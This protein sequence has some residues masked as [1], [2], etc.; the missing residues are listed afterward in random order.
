M[1]MRVRLAAGGALA[2]LLAVAAFSLRPSLPDAGADGR[3]V[4]S[5]DGWALVKP[6]AAVDPAAVPPDGRTPLTP[7]QVRQRLFREGSFAGTEPTGDWCVAQNRLTACSAL[8]ARFEYYLL[9]LGEVT[10]ADLRT[11]VFD[12]ATR[13]HGE[14]LARQIM[15]VWDKYWQLRSHAWRH[16]HDQ[17]DRSTWMPVFEE[18]R[19]VRRQ[20]LGADWAQAF[21]ADEEARFQAHYAQLESGLPPPPDPGEPVPQMA[22]GKDPA[23]VHAERVARYGEAAATRL[24]RADDEW[25]DWQ[26][27]LGA[28][29][30][31]WQRLQASPQLSDT[32]RRQEM[33]A[34]VGAHFKPDEHLRVQA[35][36]QL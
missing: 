28:A 1:N 5:T 30:Q 23:A 2:A 31:E 29:R 18:Q 4:A 26:R 12:E 34:Y 10:V 11:L 14:P 35:L 24:A 6:G 22:P 3:A 8:R 27:R 32:Q 17:A 15:A 19:L 25:A 9:G 33:S 13:A 16:R 20:I 7:E 36:L 21:Y